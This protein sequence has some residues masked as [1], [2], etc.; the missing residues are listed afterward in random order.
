MSLLN[1]FKDRLG[2]LEMPLIVTI[3]DFK[4]RKARSLIIENFTPIRKMPSLNDLALNLKFPEEQYLDPN[5]AYNALI[6]AAIIDY[7]LSYREYFAIITDRD[8]IKLR[9]Y[10]REGYPLDMKNRAT[11]KE[12]AADRL[13]QL[14]QV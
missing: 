9:K 3:N 8:P 12:L 5:M 10:F 1:K 4:S 13:L 14:S 2:L 6:A 7:E 11:M